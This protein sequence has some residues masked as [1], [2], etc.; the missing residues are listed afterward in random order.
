MEHKLLKSELL[1]A[2]KVETM[3]FTK[4]NFRALQELSVLQ[5]QEISN[6]YKNIEVNQELN[7]KLKI[8][9]EKKKSMIVYLDSI[10]RLRDKK[11]TILKKKV[12]YLK[13]RRKIEIT[14][15]DV[16]DAE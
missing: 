3:K 9:I 15:N 8:E 6:I 13:F 16:I 2:E 14:V 4:E 1:T 10:I 5:M 11:V 12:K 7:G